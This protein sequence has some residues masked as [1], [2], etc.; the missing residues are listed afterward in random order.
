MLPSGPVLGDTGFA[1]REAASAPEAERE[2][3]EPRGEG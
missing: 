1:W 2:G 3:G